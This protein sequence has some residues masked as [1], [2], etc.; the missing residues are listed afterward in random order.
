MK[1]ERINEYTLKF[2]ISYLDIE[3]RGFDREEIWYNRD[4]SEELFWQMMEEAHRKE[5]FT[6]EGPLWIQVQA[7]E[8][9]MEIIVTKAQLSQDGTNLQLPVSKD[10]RIDI[11]VSEEAGKYIS[12]EKENQKRQ[13]NEEKNETNRM[14]GME[15]GD[16][17]S[18]IIE[19]E[20][21][22]DLIALSHAFRNESMDTTLYAYKGKYY[23][24]AWFP[25]ELS[26]DRQ[27]D[28]LS[29][30]L[31]YGLDTD[32]TA[33]VLQEYGKELIHERALETISR[34]FPMNP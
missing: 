19:F 33:Y 16:G 17:I 4:R 10:R 2:Y 8:K 9:G 7:L 31:E 27:D 13:K 23:L 29:R 22:E 28:D 1:I 26:D 6:L 21:I 34:H 24:N 20:D 18:F 14:S 11:P 3:D 25:D 32:V 5:S 15:D 30:L 12:R